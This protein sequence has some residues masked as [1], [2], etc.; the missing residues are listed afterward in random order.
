V[1]GVESS[2]T[3]DNLE[4][5]YY[6][7]LVLCLCAAVGTDTAVVS[8]ALASELLAVGYVPIPVR[9]SA[10]MAQIPGLEYLSEIR[11]EDDRIRESMSA[12]NDIRRIIGHAD[13][14]AR[15]ALAEI[16]EHRAALNESDDATVPAERHCFSRL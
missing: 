16:H 3:T 6:P 7:E 12:G 11:G 8:E 4:S 10:L 2:E 5:T 15:L 1:T 14:V 13:A 9:L